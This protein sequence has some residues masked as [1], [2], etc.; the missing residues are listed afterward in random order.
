M[1]EIKLSKVSKKYSAENMKDGIFIGKGDTEY[2]EG[3][4]KDFEDRMQTL[5]IYLYPRED[6]IRDIESDEEGSLDYEAVGPQ[7]GL[8]SDVVMYNNDIRV[9]C[10]HGRVS[11]II[12]LGAHCITR[13]FKDGSTV[14]IFEHCRILPIVGQEI[15]VEQI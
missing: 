11:D 12:N 1:E 2:K 6:T 9:Y 5:V 7:D 13:V 10:K 8:I 15:I 4:L 14:M 3:T